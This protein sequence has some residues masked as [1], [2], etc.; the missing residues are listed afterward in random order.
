M[1]VNGKI[2]RKKLPS[3]DDAAT[4]T[5]TEYVAPRYE[6]EEKMVSVWEEIL[7]RKGI[8]IEDNFFEAGGNSIRII[9]LASRVSS[10][11]EKEIPITLLFQFPNIKD[12]SDYLR[13]EEVDYEEEDLDKVGLMDDL[14]KFNYN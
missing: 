11:L 9:R 12:L 3:P 5:A 8:G 6:M 1:T 4:L 13:E 7:G 10:L 2:D 14:N